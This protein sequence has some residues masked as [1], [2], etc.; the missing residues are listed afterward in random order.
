MALTR[1]FKKLV[2]RRVAADSAFG[3]ELIASLTEACEH[4]EGKPGRVMMSIRETAEGLAASGVMSKNVMR[5]FDELGAVEIKSMAR[6]AGTP[7]ASGKQ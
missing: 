7:K 4:A 5:E 1:S 2:H 3:K 6:P